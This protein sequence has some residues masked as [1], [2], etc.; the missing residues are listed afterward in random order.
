MP[1]LERAQ[2]ANA[3]TPEQLTFFESKIRPVPAEQSYERHS[4]TA[5]K[6]KGGR[7]L[8]SRTRASRAASCLSR[9]F[10]LDC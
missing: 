5:T 10:R 3:P 2:F 7:V 6:I 4:A 1:E 9:V 8:D